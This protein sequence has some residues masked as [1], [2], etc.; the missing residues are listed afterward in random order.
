MQD[1]RKENYISVQGSLVWSA[2]SSPVSVFSDMQI[3]AYLKNL[4]FLL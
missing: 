1:E 3:L 2:L 4:Y